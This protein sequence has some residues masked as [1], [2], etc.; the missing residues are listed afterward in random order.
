VTER[1]EFELGQPAE[2]D[3]RVPCPPHRLAKRRT[4]LRRESVTRRTDK[5]EL[6]EPSLQKMLRRKLTDLGVINSDTW[7]WL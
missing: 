2:D 5:C 4:T 7:K 6:S 3:W 1:I